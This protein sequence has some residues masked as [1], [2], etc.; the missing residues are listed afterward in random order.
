[1]DQNTYGVQE[2]QKPKKNRHENHWKRPLSMSEYLET[3]EGELFDH[4]LG[5]Y[6]DMFRQY[7][8]N[9]QTCFLS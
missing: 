4:V 2:N 7:Y 3:E 5:G 1:M 9:K 6:P 8:K